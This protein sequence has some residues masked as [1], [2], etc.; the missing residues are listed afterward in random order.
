MQNT[1]MLKFSDIKEY[2]LVNKH[3]K[4][5]NKEDRIVLS[6]NTI[7]SPKYKEF[8][9]SQELQSKNINYIILSKL[10]SGTYSNVFSSKYSIKSNIVNSENFAIKI[11]KNSINYKKN[12][13]LELNTLLLLNK[14][15]YNILKILDYF[16]IKDHIC[17][18]FKKYKLKLYQYYKVKIKN[19]TIHI[20]NY[21]TVIKGICN[22]LIFLDKNKIINTD[23]KPENILLE[24]C[25]VNM[26]DKH[27]K[28]NKVVLCDFSSIIK[29]DKY[30]KHYNHTS[31]WYR[32]PEIYYNFPSLNN[33]DLWSF[34]CILY[35]LWYKMVLFKS[36]YL[37][38]NKENY[39]LQKMHIYKLGYPP[40][41]YI[42]NNN[43]DEKILIPKK[44]EFSLTMSNYHQNIINSIPYNDII[45]KLLKWEPTERILPQEILNIYFSDK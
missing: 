7:I 3:C 6:N 24:L 12:G 25:S 45:Y 9:L 41:N 31:I 39:N 13:I 35:E 22:A 18:V 14:G 36:S 43:I 1:T 44:S 20:N 4:I 8:A 23:I 16:H 17:L 10:G 19:T 37:T 40:L 27:K 15:D 34:G 42:K 21:S 30:I 38:I 32:A 33:I 11:Y 29:K 26:V 5:T 28:I 2:S